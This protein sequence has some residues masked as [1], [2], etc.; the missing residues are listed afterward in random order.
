MQWE[1]FTTFLQ[2]DA[3][4]EEEFLMQLRDWKEGIA[5]YVPEALMPRLN[6]FGEQGWELV[7]MMP[8]GVGNN[9]DVLV[10]DAGSGSRTWTSKYFC[11]FKRAKTSA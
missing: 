3:R 8:V 11:V 10:Q 7:Q 5:P 2:A 1:Y 4:R 9:A 6:A